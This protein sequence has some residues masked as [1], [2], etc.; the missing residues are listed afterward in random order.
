[1]SIPLS[2]HLF[3]AYRLIYLLN[4][5]S[6]VLLTV[7]WIMVAFTYSKLTGLVLFVQ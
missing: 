3:S 6:D 4:I 7:T 2:K 1:M 5:T